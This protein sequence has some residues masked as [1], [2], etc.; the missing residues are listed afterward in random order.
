MIRK[1]GKLPEISD[2]SNKQPHLTASRRGVEYDK[3]GAML[4]VASNSNARPVAMLTWP[5]F[6]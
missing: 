3:E 4:P 2:R 6:Y 5:R 1:Y